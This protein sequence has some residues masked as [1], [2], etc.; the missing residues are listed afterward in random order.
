MVS[1]Q[2]VHT[3]LQ[4]IIPDVHLKVFRD[5][6]DCIAV[7]KEFFNHNDNM[8]EYER[9]SAK[10]YKDFI[11]PARALKSLIKNAFS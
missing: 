4:P 10:Y 7:I 1:E 2:L 5:H 9:N 3:A 8:N 6:D 11:S